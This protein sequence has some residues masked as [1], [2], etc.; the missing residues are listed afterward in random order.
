MG[1][2]DTAGD[3][4]SELFFLPNRNCGVVSAIRKAGPLAG[5]VNRRLDFFFIG[6]I[7]GFTFAMER[8]RRKVTRLR[9]GFASLRSG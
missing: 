9:F 7:R 5:G 2:F 3:P 4:P 6:V 8:R 1:I